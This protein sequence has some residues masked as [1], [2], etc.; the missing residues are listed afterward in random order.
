MPMFNACARGFACRFVLSG[1]DF[2]GTVNA[3]ARR[4][5]LVGEH[6]PQY[7]YVCPAT[8]FCLFVYIYIHVYIHRVT[9]AERSRGIS[10]AEQCC[11]TSL[12]T[13]VAKKN[14]R[15]RQKEVV[16]FHWQNSV[17]EYHC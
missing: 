9:K 16:A 6:F 17:V 15:P 8:P 1:G 12:L 4:L 7:K 10:M 11:G 5:I 14:G 13:I 3:Q 2:R